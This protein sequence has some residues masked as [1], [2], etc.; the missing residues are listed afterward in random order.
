LDRTT[1]HSL[2]PV[3]VLVPWK[4]E[5]QQQ[6]AR[7]RHRAPRHRRRHPA[8]LPKR[9][10]AWWRPGF[11]EPTTT[12]TTIRSTTR[13]REPHWLVQQRPGHLRLPM[14]ECCRWSHQPR[15]V[16]R[17]PVAVVA[18]VAVALALAVFVAVFAAT[19]STHPRRRYRG[20]TPSRSR[21]RSRRW[22]RA[23]LTMW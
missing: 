5:C 17:P 12:L 3:M 9:H 16:H 1:S 18:V 8:P 21:A 14:R 11:V 23:P 7:A 6:E 13:N 20:R 19:L 15:A 2:H 22:R 4:P 10:C